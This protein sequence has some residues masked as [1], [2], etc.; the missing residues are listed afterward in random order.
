[1]FV[2]IEVIAKGKIAVAFTEGCSHQL[3]GLVVFFER[4]VLH[5]IQHGLLLSGGIVS[6]V[7]DS[8]LFFLKEL[9]GSIIT[10]VVVLLFAGCGAGVSSQG[11]L[12]VIFL[13]ALLP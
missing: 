10:V 2:V 1:M 9:G 7:D 5:D 8:V 6:P 12:L 11:R 3:D 4:I 13:C